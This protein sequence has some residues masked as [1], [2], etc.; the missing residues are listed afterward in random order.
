MVR[1]LAL[2]L[3]V[4]APFLLLRVSR[5]FGTFAAILAIWLPIEFRLLQSIGIH[6]ATAI[7]AGMLAAIFAFRGR[8][9]ILDVSAAFDLRKVNFRRALVNFA[10]FAA[11]GIPL[12]LGIG[13]I[14]LNLRV[15]EI[16]SI[17]TLV[18]TIF[19]LN[20][21]PEEILFRGIIQHVMESILKSRTGALIL[22]ALIFGLSHLNNGPDVPNYSYFVM[23]TLA[24]V[25]YGNTWRRDKNVLTSAITHTLVNSGWRLFFRGPS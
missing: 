2:G 1:L 15:P 7:V 6:P 21:L 8:R 20:A 24:G 9:D 25:F 18:L 23:A 14:R 17:P 22:G 10:L 4:V 19:F 12:G 5:K 16:S 13:F 3:Y 11:V